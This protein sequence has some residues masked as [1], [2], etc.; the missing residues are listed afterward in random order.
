MVETLDR[1]SLSLSRS[2][3]DISH[4]GRDIVGSFVLPFVLLVFVCVLVRVC[5]KF[6]IPFPPFSR[7]VNEDA[8]RHS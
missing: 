6:F 4:D 3:T 1:Y 5:F 2:D 7:F 8:V